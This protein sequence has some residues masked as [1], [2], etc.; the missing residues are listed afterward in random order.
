[1]KDVFEQGHW[2]IIEPVMKVEVTCPSEYSTVVLNALTRRAAVLQ[3]TEATAS[4]FETI[5]CEVPLNDMFGYATELRT[6]TQ[7]TGE[8][9][10]EYSRYCPAVGTTQQM[11]IEEYQEMLN[12]Q[13]Q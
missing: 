4:D 2:I 11:V 9:S 3:G 13:T 8:Y 10:M 6:L 1:M 5:I 7:G 12:A